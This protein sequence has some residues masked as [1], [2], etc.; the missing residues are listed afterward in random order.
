MN[1]NINDNTFKPLKDL[2][3]ELGVDTAKIKN[4]TRLIKNSGLS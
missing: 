4:T 1:G 2:C 3:E